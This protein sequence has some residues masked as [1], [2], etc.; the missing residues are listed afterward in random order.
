MFHERRG[1]VQEKESIRM[2]LAIW[3]KATGP[4]QKGDWRGK[5][6]VPYAN[7]KRGTQDLGGEGEE[8]NSAGK[9]SMKGSYKYKR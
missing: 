1:D 7:H 3:R 9:N 8:R 6:E 4:L 5:M 2:D